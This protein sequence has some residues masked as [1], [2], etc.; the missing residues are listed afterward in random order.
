M[1]EHFHVSIWKIY[2]YFQCTS[3]SLNFVGYFHISK[4][5]LKLLNMFFRVGFFSW[6]SEKFTSFPTWFKYIG[7]I[8]IYIPLQHQT[9]SAP[10][11]MLSTFH[12]SSPHTFQT[13]LQLFDIYSD[14]VPL[15]LWNDHN[16]S[17][18]IIT[19]IN[20]IVV[21]NFISSS[22]CSHSNNKQH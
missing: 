6:T 9:K 15:T 3:I 1:V 17:Q 13:K 7:N 12:C 18:C 2:M 16:S 10:I 22:N 14:I 21:L 11:P 20:T 8:H 4:C 5:N 19:A